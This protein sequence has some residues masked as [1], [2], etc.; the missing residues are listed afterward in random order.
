MKKVAILILIFLCLIFNVNGLKYACAVDSTF[1]EGIYT[2]TDLNLSPDTVY[3]IKNVSKSKAVGVF[4]YDED[5]VNM[6]FIKLGPDSIK[7][8]TI[9]MQANYIFI[10]VGDGEITIIPKAQ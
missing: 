3:T 10:V 5:Y 8:D 7:K 6:Q 9:P 1:K 4:I 2:I